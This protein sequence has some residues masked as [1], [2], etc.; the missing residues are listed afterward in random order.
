MSLTKSYNSSCIFVEGNIHNTYLPSVLIA[1]I[2][3]YSP[4]PSELQEM[5]AL[6]I[7]QRVNLLFHYLF[8]AHLFNF[9][10]VLVSPPAFSVSVASA[11]IDHSKILE[12]FT[13]KAVGHNEHDN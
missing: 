8:E 10:L 3:R 2:H 1:T 7:I 5:C 11:T 4:K 13:I 9:Y 12:C 6:R